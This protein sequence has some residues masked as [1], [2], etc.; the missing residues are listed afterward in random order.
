[1]TLKIAPFSPWTKQIYEDGAHHWK[2]TTLVAKAKDLKL[3]KMPI[4]ALNLVGMEP[5]LLSMR[6]WVGHIKSV[7]DA[8][9][10]Y[11]IILDEH[12]RVMDGR[13]RIAKALLDG[14]DTI[15]YVRFDETPS[16][17]WYEDE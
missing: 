15:D 2:V 4:E 1:M 5:N 17:D 14:E 11:P 7:L 8:D 16:P 12:G 9:L 10:S 6:N 3:R 13:H